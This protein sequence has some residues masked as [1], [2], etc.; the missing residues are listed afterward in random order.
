MCRKYQYEIAHLFISEMTAEAMK[1]RELARRLDIAGSR[2][3]ESADALADGTLM[4]WQ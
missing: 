3:C 4:R 2:I 1:S